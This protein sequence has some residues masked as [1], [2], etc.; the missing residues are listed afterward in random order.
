M[1]VLIIFVSFYPVQGIVRVYNTT[2]YMTRFYFYL[3]LVAV[4]A[5]QACNGR[6]PAADATGGQTFA[7]RADTLF[8]RAAARQQAGEY[9]GAI[10]LYAQI[11]ADTAAGDGD[12]RASAAVVK[13]AMVQMMYCH[14]FSGRRGSAA[15][16]Y[17]AL[18]ADT[19]HWMVRL[20]PRTV[21]VCLAYSLYEAARLTE[22][23]AVM[24]RALA[25]PEDGIPADE[26]YAHYGMAGAIYNQTGDIPRAVACTERCA[27]LLRTLGKTTDLANALGNLISQYEQVGDFARSLAAYEELT[28]LDTARITPYHRCIAEVNVVH[29]YEEW[30]LDA[31]A[32]KHLAMARSAA[33]ASAIPEARLRVANLAAWLHLTRGHTAAAARTLDTLAALL[34]PGESFYRTYYRDFRLIADLS[35]APVAAVSP[36]SVPVP[37]AASARPAGLSASPLSTALSTPSAPV[38]SPAS[39]AHDLTQRALRRLDTLRRGIRDRLHCDVCYLLARALDRRGLTRPAL[40]A[41]TACAPY[42]AAHGLLATQ[43]NVHRALARLHTRTGNYAAATRAYE[44]CDTASRAFADRRNAAMMAQFR[45]RYATR[46]KEQANV[47][48]RA[49]V[50]LQRRTLQYYTLAAIAAALLV[51]LLAG[52]AV[53]HHRALRRRHELDARQHEL[54]VLRAE[55]AERLAAAQEAK[56]RRMLSE[57]QELNRRNELLRAELSETDSAARLRRLVENLS[58]CLLSPGDEQEFRR[59]FLLLHPSFLSSLR[60]ACPAVGRSEEMLAMLLR[61]GLNNEEIALTLG[62]HRSSVNTARSRLRHKF[63]LGTGESLEEIVMKLEEE[64]GEES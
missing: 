25:R 18:A 20:F 62:I 60:R 38:L 41:Y 6:H 43:R 53:M 15:D 2:V 39:A 30:G 63:A 45:V 54:D 26:L 58:P 8:S 24:D 5:L 46:E 10:G 27:A 1:R 19:A 9:D 13:E 52:W 47:L 3:C 55:A 11:F 59:Q 36:S 21:E 50:L 14:F 37:A 57:R 48:L 56:L 49:E 17:E 61:L 32:D 33:A 34:P 12:V 4:V 35:A 51:L 16:R 29:L 31:E 28:A 64:A 40:D 7:Q 42:A 44:R 23:V 22:A